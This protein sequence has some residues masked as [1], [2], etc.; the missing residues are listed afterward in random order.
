MTELDVSQTEELDLIIRYL[1]PDSSKQAAT[2]RACD[3][4]N[5]KVTVRKI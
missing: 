5:P 1:G 3:A 2:L 4:G